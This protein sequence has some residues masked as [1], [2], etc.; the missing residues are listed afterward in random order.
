[1]ISLRIYGEKFPGEEDYTLQPPTPLPQAKS[2]RTCSDF[3]ALTELTRLGEPSV[4]M[5][6]S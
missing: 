1:M 3:L 4:Y 5:E 2:A 6:K